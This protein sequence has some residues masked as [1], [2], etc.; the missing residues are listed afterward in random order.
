MQHSSP[1]CK[2]PPGSKQK[3]KLPKVESL[4][5]IERPLVIK[6]SHS[7]CSS[8]SRAG[9][10]SDES[11]SSHSNKSDSSG[12]GGGDRPFVLDFTEAMKLAVG[13]ESTQRLAVALFTM[14]WK[15][16]MV[17]G[18]FDKHEYN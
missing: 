15:R 4:S 17:E 11:N 3:F 18:M 2:L 12:V 16:E 14:M 1:T 9:D 8:D 5:G 6:Q 13:S 7:L 10:F